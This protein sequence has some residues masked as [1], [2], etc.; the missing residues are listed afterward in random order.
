MTP[1]RFRA[2]ADAYG[3]DLDRWPAAERDAARRHLRQRPG[4]GA[5]RQAAA[6]L[7]AVLATWTVPGPGA[8][9]AARIA[10]TLARRHAH[11]RRLR[12][13]LSSLGAA[14]ALAGGVAAGAVVVMLAAPAA[15]RMTP[16]LYELR[17]LGAP[18]DLDARAPAS[19]HFE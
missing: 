1:D 12:V 15:E 16:P 18:L 6:G 11:A 4:A 2:L 17:V 7:D 5:A 9:L 8:A 19:G 10:A 14:T 13:W 3:G